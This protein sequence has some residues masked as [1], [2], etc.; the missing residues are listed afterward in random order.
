MMKAQFS[1]QNP[2]HEFGGDMMKAQF[3]SQ[4]ILG[5]NLTVI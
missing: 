4:K 3:S 5:M 1:C 2:G